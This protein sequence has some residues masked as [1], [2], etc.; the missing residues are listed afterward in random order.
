M[1]IPYRLILLMVL[2]MGF[3]CRVEAA[4]TPARMWDNLLDITCRFSWYPRQDL[5]NLLKLKSEE[6]GQSLEEY[7]AELLKEVTG[8]SPPT[9]RI[10]SDQFVSGLPWRQ[11]YRL[12]L[13]EF[14]LFLATEKEEHLKN[15]R[16]ALSVLDKKTDQ[17]EI[18]F[19]NYL[20]RAH[21]AALSRDRDAFIPLV[22]HLWRNVVLRYETESLAFPSE[23]SRAGFVRNLPYLYENLAHIVI[24]KAILENEIPDLYPLVPVILDIQRK[25]TVENGYKAMVDQI[26]E[27][28]HGSNSDNRNLN[29]A[30]ALLEA[31]A[32]RY[33][34]EDEKDASLLASKYNLA[35]RYLLLAYDWAD[36]DKGRTVI[37]TQH[38]GFL[39]YVV[40]RLT[41]PSDSVA[42]NPFFRNIPVMANDS[43][44]K[45]VPFFH[46]LAVPAVR[47]EAG[48]AER[49]ELAEGFEDSDAYLQAMHQLLDSFA[50]LS[51]VLSE[52]YKAD[53][54][55]EGA[56]IFPAAR[57][58]ELY[59][60]LFDRYARI[61]SE[62][63]PDSAYFM[64][65][66]AAR[67]LGELYRERARYTV[68]GHADE[69]AFAYQMQAAE[70][71]P[72]DLPGIL[73][74]AF[75]CSLNGQVQDYF[76]NSRPLAARL[77][78]SHGA[79][80]WSARN[81]TDFDALV[82]L[83]PVVVPEVVDNAYTLLGHVP[84]AASED[85]L[86]TRAV[87]MARVL[88]DG[89]GSNPNDRTEETLEA[90][91]RGRADERMLPFYELKSQ[92]Y[93]APDSPVHTFI[94]T[95]YNEVPYENHR[96]VAL[97]RDLHKE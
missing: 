71:F 35:R 1:K 91:G 53:R 19:W 63:L 2:F 80:T 21:E 46:R 27:R 70:I 13:A 87:A 68:D 44:E 57:P 89:H 92:L 93:G 48:R 60:D 72:L 74:M 12:S 20:Y 33:E 97:L 56:D 39:N 38:M 26:I 76:R 64:A 82:E 25:L 43:I 85:V 9:A 78:V 77:R 3:G 6:Y 84:E 95:L 50:K 51:I 34:F 42:A 14:C 86:F 16:N 59:C 81:P 23:S 40:R 47:A 29:F 67:E 7:R 4:E 69:L 41:D 75:Q 54:G 66:Y 73:Q 61:N 65:A 15:A 83:V 24:R 52:F 88:E 17:A 37:L 5:Q 94:R 62:I 30:V 22:Y 32:K 45:M 79:A 8:G 55:Q 11:Y 10:R 36:T 58:L 96:Y 31:T 18:E 90:I 49:E 28:M